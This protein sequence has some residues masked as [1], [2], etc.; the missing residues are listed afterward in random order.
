MQHVAELRFPLKTLTAKPPLTLTLMPVPYLRNSKLNRRRSWK[1]QCEECSK[2][3]TQCDHRGAAAAS[4]R[5][6][7]DAG[8][9]PSG[10]DHVP[11]LRGRLGVHQVKEE[12]TEVRGAEHILILSAA[13]CVMDSHRNQAPVLSSRPHLYVISLNVGVTVHISLDLESIK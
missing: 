8:R 5:R 13:L 2:K 3:R 12:D 4:D 11:G 1:T 6:R 9:N 7:E 10:G